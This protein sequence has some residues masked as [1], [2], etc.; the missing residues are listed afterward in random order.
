MK[1]LLIPTD[2]TQQ[3][4][5]GIPA[6]LQKYYPEKINFVLVHMLKITDN[7]GELLMLSRRNVEYRQIPDNFYIRCRETER[8]YAERIGKINI[9]FFYGSTVATFN[10]FLEAHE[11]NA[12]VSPHDGYQLLFKNS[13]DPEIL[14]SRSG[15]EVLPAPKAPGVL[16][17]VIIEEP[18]LAEQH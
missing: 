12:I 3:S 7:V 11:I 13:I 5:Q 6:L 10:N 8:R 16:A 4:V 15:I 18:E 17:D 2:F 9:T 14:L 1:T